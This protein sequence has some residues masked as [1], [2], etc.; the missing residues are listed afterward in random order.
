MDN[1]GI[2]EDIIPLLHHDDRDY[3]DYKTPNT[4]RT[5]EASFIVLVST[6]KEITST[7]HLRQKAG[8]IVQALRCN[9]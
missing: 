5:D 7:L 2:D 9:G 6:E 4:S 8:C 1:S 3:D